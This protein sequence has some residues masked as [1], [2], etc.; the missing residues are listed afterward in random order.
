MWKVGSELQST[1]L[2]PVDRL[3]EL[4]Q[5]DQLDQLDWLDPVRVPKYGFT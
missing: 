1:T 2:D 4:D 3:D 5:L